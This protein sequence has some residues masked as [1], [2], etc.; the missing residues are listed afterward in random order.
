MEKRRRGFKENSKVGN[1]SEQNRKSKFPSR[2][3]TLSKLKGPS[4]NIVSVASTDKKNHRR[5]KNI[6]VLPIKFVTN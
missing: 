5:L 6:K 2:R 3:N 1:R 4:G